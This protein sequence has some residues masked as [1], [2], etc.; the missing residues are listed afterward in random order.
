MEQ[1]QWK[2]IARSHWVYCVRHGLKWWVGSNIFSDWLD[3]SKAAWIENE[4]FL[5]RFLEVEPYYPPELTRFKL[6]LLVLRITVLAFLPSDRWSDGCK[7][8]WDVC[9][10]LP[11]WRIV[12]GAFRFDPPY[13]PAADS[14]DDAPF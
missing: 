9:E 14:D 7:P 6:V 12:A 3:E 13:T 8:P 11:W 1:G 4:E 10:Y 5:S 2:N